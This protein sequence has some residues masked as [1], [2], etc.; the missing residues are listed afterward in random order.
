MR[1]STLSSWLAGAGKR[2]E[3]APTP[4]ALEEGVDRLLVQGWLVEPPGKPSFLTLGASRLQ[5]QSQSPSQGQ[6][7]RAVHPLLLLL[8]PPLALCFHSVI[9]VAAGARALVELRGQLAALLPDANRCHACKHV[10][11]MG[12]QAFFTGRELLPHT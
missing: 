8:L 10:V 2:L 4:E 3:K 1:R 12:E 9:V 7:M 6:C 5:S 11:L